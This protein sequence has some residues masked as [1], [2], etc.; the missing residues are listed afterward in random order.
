MTK[1]NLKTLT[2]AGIHYLLARRMDAL[3]EAQAL[4]NEADREISRRAAAQVR[5]KQAAAGTKQL[6]VTSLRKGM[7][8][9]VYGGFS[10]ITQIRASHRFF[11][12]HSMTEDRLVVLANGKTRNLSIF[13][14]V[15]V[16]A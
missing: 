3:K 10:K 1:T 16:K 9:K 14:R 13:D 2:R 12:R 6:Q 4:V 8:L 15:T 11:D 5:A 7:E